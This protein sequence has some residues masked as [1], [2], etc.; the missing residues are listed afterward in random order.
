MGYCFLLCDNL[1]TAPPRLSIKLTSVATIPCTVHY[2][3]K[4]HADLP[5]L[6]LMTQ[7]LMPFLRQTCHGSTVGRS[8]AFPFGNK[9]FVWWRYIT[10]LTLQTAKKTYCRYKRTIYSA[11]PTKCVAIR[12]MTMQPNSNACKR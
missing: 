4:T 8:T 3:S 1:R 12:E 7:S 6:L 5:P 9:L 10:E 11:G 2:V